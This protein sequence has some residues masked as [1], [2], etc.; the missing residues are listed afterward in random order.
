MSVLFDNFS[1]R[2]RITEEGIFHNRWYNDLYEEFNVAERCYYIN[3]IIN[4]ILLH[5][6][7][8]I[9]IDSL[10]EFIDIMGIESTNKLLS[11]GILKILD[12]WFEAVFFE[13]GENS[14]MF[15]NLQKQTDE[16]QS[17]IIYRLRNQ[18]QNSQCSLI[19][20]I[21]KNELIN[22]E[23]PSF[24]DNQAIIN[25]DNDLENDRIRE[26]LNITSSKSWEINNNDILQVTRLYLLNRNI[27]WSKF[28]NTDE[29]FLESGAK[30]ML[31]SKMGYNYKETVLNGINE[32]WTAK[33]IPNLAFLYKQK[34]ITIDDII[35][36][37]EDVDG[38]KFRE[39]IKSTDYDIIEIRKKLME[40]I[41]NNLLTNFLRYSLIEGIGIFSEPF[42]IAASLMD[43]FLL[44]CKKWKPQIY[45][46]STIPQYLKE[47]EKRKY[48]KI[49]E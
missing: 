46:D 26:L 15:M 24:I 8:Y 37:R 3:N 34:L 31:M 11:C 47:L 32:I 14:N 17:K 12:G 4:S 10:E 35:E 41:P 25:L 39:W 48:I 9:R 7:I 23:E 45:L 33:N 43:F 22:F 28:I 36:L 13:C 16:V 20:Y 5:D 49:F 21:L 40:K 44:Q 1:Y 18:Y 6:L 42:G 30:I 29:I 38:I 2:L 27:E 19:K